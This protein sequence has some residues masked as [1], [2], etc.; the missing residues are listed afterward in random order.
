MEDFFSSYINTFTAIGVIISLFGFFVT[1]LTLWVAVKINS[2]IGKNHIRTKQ[3]DHICTL[4]EVLNKSKITVSFATY[5]GGGYSAIGN[6]ILFNIFEIGSY[7]SIQPEGINKE[8]EEDTVLFDKNSNQIIDIK[9]FIDHPL[10]PREIVDELLNFYNRSCSSIVPGR[11][12]TYIKKF[13][14]ISSNVWEEKV[15]I[16]PKA[17]GNLIESSNQTY[18][19]WLSLKESSKRLKIVIGNWLIENGIEEH[20]IREDFKNL[21]I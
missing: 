2:Q 3:I 4:I 19:T 11:D 9:S 18:V 21:D 14:V 20:N 5:N 10:S 16:D 13:V 15:L 1:V 8:Y 7:D 12:D 17:A 6:A